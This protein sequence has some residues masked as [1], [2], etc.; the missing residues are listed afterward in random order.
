MKHLKKFV[1]SFCLLMS[2]ATTLMSQNP[3]VTKADMIEDFN[4]SPN[5]ELIVY[6]ELTAEGLPQVSMKNLKTGEITLVSS[7]NIM[8]DNAMTELFSGAD[9]LSDNVV[10]FCK[11]GYMVSF[12]MKEK[13]S[14][15]L[16]K[17]PE[18]MIRFVK[19]SNDGKGVYWVG[20]D[21][22]Y[23]ASVEKGIVAQTDKIDETVMSLTIDGQN[24]VLCAT[25]A[26]KVYCFD[27]LDKKKDMTSEMTKLVAKPYLVEATPNDNC[28][29]V[30]GKEG[31]FTIDLSAGKSMK[32]MDNKK[33]NP[34]YIMRL[35]PE[36]KALYYNT[37]NEKRIIRKLNIGATGNDN[38][39][40]VLDIASERNSAP[41]PHTED[42][43][44]YKV[45]ELAEFPGGE[46]AMRN[47]IDE[48]FK[49]PAT[50]NDGKVTADVVVGADG[51]IGEITVVCSEDVKKEILRV[52]GLMPKWKPAKV[53][54]KPVPMFYSISFIVK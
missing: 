24:R 51:Q 19:A 28:F 36:G 13:K 23:Y 12:D 7:V 22:V 44:Y 17:L 38:S 26:G 8:S 35:S 32:L 21:R 18:A 33:E 1:F 5:G 16:F 45:D 15:Q 42:G 39:D 43:I 54:G 27:G 9:F 11:D 48:H 31:V 2:F 46:V 14:R 52:I 10:V 3:F 47:F 49:Q 40:I 4:V 34:L 41:L 30:A 6:R 20:Y 37:M 25:T 50:R 29:I 53:G